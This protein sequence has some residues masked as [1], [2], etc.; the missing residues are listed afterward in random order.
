MR[1]EDEARAAVVKE[2]MEW[3]GTPYMPCARVK[4]KN[5][6]V[7]CLTF[8]AGVFEAAGVI[9]PVVIPHYP[10]DWH[11]HQKEERYMNGVREYCNEIEGPPLPGDIVL[12]KFGHCF[13]HGAI[14]IKWP[15]IIHAWANRP[16]CPD[17]AEQYSILKT[18]HEV[19]EL[20]GTPR[21]KKFFTPKE[22]R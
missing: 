11:L 20:R 4:G 19:I 14:V 15:M 6:G 22:W 16:V 5:G 13:A 3:E 21:P 8:V 9:D 10:R 7:D 18:V 1:T 12:W 2:A 17:N